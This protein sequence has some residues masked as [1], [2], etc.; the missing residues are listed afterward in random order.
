MDT[1]A[2]SA[3]QTRHPSK[4]VATDH[5]ALGLAFKKNQEIKL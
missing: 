4:Q 2:P 3:I 5:M 1:H